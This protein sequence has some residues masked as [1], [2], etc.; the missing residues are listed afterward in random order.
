[1]RSWVLI[2]VAAALVL[3]ACGGR[4]VKKQYEYE[5][6]LYLGLDG[7]ATLNVNASVPALVAL[8]AVDLNA[9]PRSRFERE[10]LRAFYE[11]PGVTVTAL[12]SSRRYGR[13]FVHVSMDVADVR[14]LQRLAPFAW[15][16]YRFGRE[17]DVYEF[18][19]T[20]GAPAGRSVSD[21]GWDGS[22]LVAFRMHLPS[23]IAYHNAPSRRTERGN[24]LEWEQ[25]LAER[26][27]GT[28]VDIDVQMETQSILARTL[29]LF[30]AMIVA[31]FGTL[32]AI[33]WW[34]ARRGRAEGFAD[35]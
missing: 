18:K 28:P 11:G 14:S 5:E 34:V 13:R 23:K 24:I 33:I 7:S 25:T 3:S 1:M 26:L 31:A 21:A 29:L 10:R 15:S 17:G 20:V 2:V 6:E 8:R 19:Q 9:N 32:A 22:E 27:R 30:G 12:S 16:T 4:L 35:S